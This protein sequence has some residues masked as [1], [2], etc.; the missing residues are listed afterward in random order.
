MAVAETIGP[1]S[2]FVAK[3]VDVGGATKSNSL[4]AG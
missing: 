3:S 4:V 2:V 1:R